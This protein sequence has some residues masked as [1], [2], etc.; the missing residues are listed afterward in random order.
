MSGVVTH[1]HLWA[2]LVSPLPGDRATR[3]V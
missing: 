3:P 1:Q 2:P